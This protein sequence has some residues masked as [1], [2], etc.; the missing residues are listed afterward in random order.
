[1]SFENI[2]V[3]TNRSIGGIQLDAV[4]SEGHSNKSR[5]STNPVELGADVSDHVI[6]EP[7]VINIVAEVTDTPLTEVQEG[8]IV[9]DNTGLFGSSTTDNITRSVAAY[10]AMLQLQETK[11]LLQV[12]TRLLLYTNMM[13]TSLS[14][15]QDKDTSRIVR[16]NI[17]MEELLITESR[18]I[19]LDPEQLAEGSVRNQGTSADARGR[20]EGVEIDDN[21]NTSVLER[22]RQWVQE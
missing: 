1:M 8:D 21:T 17:T 2:L 14:T 15:S 18:I 20:Q 12:Q 10:N 11:T 9:D 4:L 22:L 19:R 3:R 6:V 5:K 16:L 13:I 7:K